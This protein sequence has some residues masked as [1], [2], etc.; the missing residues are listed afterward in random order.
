M[1]NQPYSTLWKITLLVAIG[2]LIATFILVYQV[3]R[4]PQ[5]VFQ[6]NVISPNPT[7]YLRAEPSAGSNIVTVLERG[8]MVYVMDTVMSQDIRWMKIEFGHFSGWIPDTYLSFE[9][10]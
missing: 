9:S 1:H 3:L 6:A 10:Q 2:L 7:I 8:S 4:M 5:T